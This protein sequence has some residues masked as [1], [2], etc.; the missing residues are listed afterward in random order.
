MSRSCRAVLW[1]RAHA[2]SGFTLI[3][4][5]VSLVLV[6]MVLGLV[7]MAA[8]PVLDD[9]DEAVL[10][11]RILLQEHKI[12]PQAVRW[13]A[14]GKLHLEAGRVRLAAELLDQAVLISPQLA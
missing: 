12:Y 9:D 2:A 11:A 7:A 3:E 1:P 8:V 6:G 5:L 4:V 13:F 14:E 10:A